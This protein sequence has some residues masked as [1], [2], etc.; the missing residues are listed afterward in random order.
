MNLEPVG[1]APGIGLCV[2][3]QYRVSKITRYERQVVKLLRH[4]PHNH[5]FP[6]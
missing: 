5:I 1:T 4:M 2:K 3:T 6:V